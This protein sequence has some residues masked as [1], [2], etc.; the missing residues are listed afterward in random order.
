[1]NG[2][3][4]TRT[5]RNGGKTELDRAMEVRFVFYFF[6]SADSVWAYR[7]SPNFTAGETLSLQII[8]TEFPDE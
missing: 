4:N 5:Q 7:D 3:N 1:M 2:K 6:L 8:R